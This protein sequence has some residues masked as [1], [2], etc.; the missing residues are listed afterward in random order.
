MLVLRNIL[1]AVL[2]VG[3]LVPVV[4]TADD[5]VLLS[6]D[7]AR[8]TPDGPDEVRD[9]AANLPS[10]SSVVFWVQFEHM[11]CPARQVVMPEIGRAATVTLLERALVSV[12][13][14]KR[15]VRGPPLSAAA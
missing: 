12:C 3:L 15:A 14:P 8:L 9:R 13:T 1:L 6:A 10:D 2:C 4:S 5:L 7:I 11:D